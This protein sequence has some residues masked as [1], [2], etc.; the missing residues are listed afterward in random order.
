MFRVIVDIFICD[1]EGEGSVEL[2]YNCVIYYLYFIFVIDF[3]IRR[4][5]LCCI[6]FFNIKKEGLIIVVVNY[7]L[8]NFEFVGLVEVKEC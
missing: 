5:F 7:V 2:G 4:K 3:V 1:W 6:V 8:M